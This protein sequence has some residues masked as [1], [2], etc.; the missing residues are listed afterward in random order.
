MK[1]VFTFLFVFGMILS[2]TAQ[3]SK[4]VTIKEFTEGIVTFSDGDLNVSSPISSFNKIALE[5]AS[6]SIVLTKE[7][8]AASLLEAKKYKACIITVGVYTIVKVSDFS[9]TIMSGSWGCRV[10]FGSGYVQKVTLNFKE[11]Y[12]NN[13]IGVPNSQRRMMFLFE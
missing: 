10:P 13:I 4:D 1:T 6:K 5:Q 12:I 8:M 9:K 2:L 3:E 7:N 11:D